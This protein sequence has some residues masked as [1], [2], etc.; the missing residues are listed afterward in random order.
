MFKAILISWVLNLCH[1]F[2]GLHLFDAGS[3]L[4][5]LPTACFKLFAKRAHMHIPDNNG[6]ADVVPQE[7]GPAKV[8]VTGSGIPEADPGPDSSSIIWQ[9][10]LSQREVEGA[11]VWSAADLSPLGALPSPAGLEGKPPF[12]YCH[13][14]LVTTHSMIIIMSPLKHYYHFTT[15]CECD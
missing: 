11:T 1:R 12:F 6:N 8:A 7:P 2:Y 3:C 10:E 4:N 14:F 9:E 13:T 15:R 5:L